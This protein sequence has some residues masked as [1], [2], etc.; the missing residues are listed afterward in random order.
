MDIIA[1]MK[2]SASLKEEI[3]IM[4]FDHIFERYPHETDFDEVQRIC[5]IDQSTFEKEGYITREY[6]SGY[7]EARVHELIDEM[8]SSYET[9]VQRSYEL[10]NV[11]K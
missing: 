1:I 4:V 6:F 11:L 3:N 5:G 10:F 8:I 9:I 2:Q 7:S